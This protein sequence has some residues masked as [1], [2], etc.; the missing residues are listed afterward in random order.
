M[1]KRNYDLCIATRHAP[2]TEIVTWKKEDDNDKSG[3]SYS[4]AAVTADIGDTV[5]WSAAT[6]I[7]SNRQYAINVVVDERRSTHKVIV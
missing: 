2:D 5:D 6:L 1:V 4:L 7:S 3:T